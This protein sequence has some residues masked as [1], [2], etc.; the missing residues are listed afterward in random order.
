[1]LT[2]RMQIQAIADL[3]AGLGPSD[4]NPRDF[5]EPLRSLYRALL[6]APRDRDGQQKALVQ[7][8]SDEPERD[9]IIGAILAAVPGERL[10]F[11]SLEEIAARLPPIAWLWPDWIPL[12]MITLLGS[13]PG[14]GKSYVALD[15]ARR[16][17]HGGSFPDDAPVP[18]PGGNVI[19]VDAENVPRIIKQRAEGWGM[20]TSRLYLMGP[21]ERACIDLSAFRDQEHLQEMAYT[22]KPALIVI[23]SLSTVSTRGENNVEDVR[24]LLNFLNRL[25]QEPGCA[26]L[27]VHHLRKRGPLPS[28]GPLS[29]DDFRG[30]SH[31]IAMARSV[32][33]LS[34][35]RTGPEPDRNGPRRLEV[36]KTNLARYPE[37]LGV[38]FL[39]GYPAGVT[40]QYGPPPQ[41]YRKP[42][43]LDKC[44][45]WLVETLREAGEP[46]KPAELV[47][48]GEEA[49][50]CRATLYDARAGLGRRVRDTHKKR[51]PRNMWALVE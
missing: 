2:Q 50:F 51:S 20:D 4:H 28:D 34:L 12:G 45:A 15:L 11:P 30:S 24:Q 7:V 21:G 5:S 35:I 31:I 23:D 18:Q 43:K 39:S 19:Y 49:G 33:G 25:A 22:L 17:I 9:A 1:M 10:A 3:L 44:K 37:P 13:I 6:E 8:L 47:A 41:A 26:L 27:L 48:L 46:L 42:T 14:A 40:L 16:V 32:L 38:E 36:V 29:V